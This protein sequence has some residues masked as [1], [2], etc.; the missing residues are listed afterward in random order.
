MAASYSPLTLRR[1]VCSVSSLALS[2]LVNH[3]ELEAG[4]SAPEDGDD[5]SI[6]S[7]ELT[8]LL[9]ELGTVT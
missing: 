1:A 9:K 5:A 3:T 8:A 2:T 6:F 7:M 4:V